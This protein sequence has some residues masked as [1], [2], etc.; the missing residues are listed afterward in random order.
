MALQMLDGAGEV[1]AAVEK[2]PLLNPADF[3]GKTAEEI[4]AL[5]KEAG[6]ISKGQAQLLEKAL[7]GHFAAFHR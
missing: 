4:E 7:T 2:S 6:L 5:A 3:A 1:E